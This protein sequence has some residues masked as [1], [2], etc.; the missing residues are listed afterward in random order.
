MT[1]P[2]RTNWSSLS[3]AGFAWRLVGGLDHAEGDSF[4]H[5]WGGVD[6]GLPLPISN[7]SAWVY[8]V[9]NELTSRVSAL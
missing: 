4:P 6:Y 7:S 9:T 1:Q 3:P 8:A 5:I 2:V